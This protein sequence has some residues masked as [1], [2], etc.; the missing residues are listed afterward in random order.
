[1][2]AKIDFMSEKRIPNAQ[3]QKLEALLCSHGGVYL[4]AD[5]RHFLE[6]VLCPAHL[7]IT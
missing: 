7:L 2:K 6:A 1:M 4:K 5:T 3:W